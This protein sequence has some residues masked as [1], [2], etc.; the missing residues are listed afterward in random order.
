M[1]VSIAIVPITPEH[2]EG[3]HR[4][5]DI[6]ATPARFSAAMQ[7]DD[8]GYASRIVKCLHSRASSKHRYI[9]RSQN[10]D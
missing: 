3:F 7:H 8:N 5:V 6:V 4:V 2:V 10:Q 9:V 1:S